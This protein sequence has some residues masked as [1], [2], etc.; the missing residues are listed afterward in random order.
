[1][2]LSEEEVTAYLHRM[3]VGNPDAA[4]WAAEK[5]GEHI[6][7]IEQELAS[8]R[9]LFV[10]LAKNADDRHWA[11]IVSER[12]AAMK[13]RDRLAAKL[14]VAE[15]FL[16]AI[17][18]QKMLEGKDP[19]AVNWFIRRGREALSRIKETPG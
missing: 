9:E 11:R 3:R 10:D 13:D 19:D 8:A 5:M 7:A 18:D 6:E 16:T 1:M 14:K 17:A 4:Q 15:D 12:N 2:R